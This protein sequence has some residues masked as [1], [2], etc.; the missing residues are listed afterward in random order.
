MFDTT[1]LKLHEPKKRNGT[2][3]GNGKF[4]IVLNFKT[5]DFALLFLT[6]SFYYNHVLLLFIS[7]LML[8]KFDEI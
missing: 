8:S 4:S 2:K 3:R 6:P 7:L 5:V 1:I